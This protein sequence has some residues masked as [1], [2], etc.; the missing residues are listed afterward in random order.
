MSVEHKG[1]H[2][3]GFRSVHSVLAF[4][5]SL[6]PRPVAGGCSHM[7][8]ALLRPSIL[9]LRINFSVRGW[10]SDWLQLGQVPIPSAAYEVQGMASCTV[11]AATG[12]HCGDGEEEKREG[13]SLGCHYELSRYPQRCLPY[14][15]TVHPGVSYK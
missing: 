14:H 12:P 5:V 15:D 11:M 13:S 10:D 8:V 1:K 7:E 4:C 2:E 3:V 9:S 6:S